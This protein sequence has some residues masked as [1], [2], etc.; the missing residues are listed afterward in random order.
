MSPVILGRR[1]DALEKRLG[2]KADVPL[3]AAAVVSEDG[4]AFLDRCRQLLTEWEPPERGS[5][6][7]AR[8]S[9]T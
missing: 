9:A 2:V 7:P 6:R 8:P 5:R 3:D 1:I 4:A